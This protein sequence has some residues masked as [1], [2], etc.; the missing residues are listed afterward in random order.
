MGSI[1]AAFNIATGALEADQAALNIAANN[2]ANANTPG[3]TR[4]TPV[5]QEND[6]VQLNGLRFGMGAS[7]TAA[8]SQR[9]LVLEK[10][11]QQQTQLESASSARLNALQQVQALF[12]SATSA[13]SDAGAASGIGTDLS[14]LFDAFASLEGGPSDTALREQVLSAAGS[15]AADFNAAAAQIQN[16]RVALDQQGASVVTQANSL[17]RNIAQLNVQIQSSSPGS[18]AGTLEDQ[19]QQNLTDLSKLIGIRTIATENNGLTVTTTGGTL[20]VAEGQSFQM[21]AGQSGG[22]T[23]FY[24]SAN[25]DVTQQLTA[26]GG[27][28]GGI[29]AARDQDLPQVQSTLDELAFAVAGAVNQQNGA[30]ADLNGSAGGAIFS[31]P[32]SPAGSA[33]GISVTMTDPAGIAAAA[34]GK[35]SSDN[36][37]SIALA[38]IRTSSIAGG[39]TAASFFSDFVTTLGSLVSEVSTD[40]TAQGAALTQLQNQIGSLSG[41]DLNEE[42]AQLEA[43]EQ[44]YQAASKLFTILTQVMTAA[45]N[46]GVQSSYA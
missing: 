3:Y 46:L 2:T 44:S 15:L 28:L 32:A 43:L 12:S 13:G 8:R 42:A 38:G 11:V 22:V 34:T 23:H 4:E 29:L 36:E 18:D 25:N 9:S 5:W 16:Q 41:V 27:Q 35:G 45:L 24:D 30:G 31:V 14:T 20:L 6:S 39:T 21:T 26:G 37:N 40:N 19:R 7:V 33:A 17:L 1:R 10:A